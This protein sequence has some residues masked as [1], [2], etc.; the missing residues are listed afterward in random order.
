MITRLGIDI[1]GTFTDLYSFDSENGSATTCK[2]PTTKED[3]TVGVLKAIAKSQIQLRSITD[4]IHGS[5]IATNAVIERKLPTVP[6][7]TTKGFRDIIEIGRYH[8]QDLYDPYQTKPLPLTSRRYRY[9]VN[10]RVDSSGN[11]LKDLDLNELSQV[12]DKIR[13]LRTDTIAI[14]FVNS[15]ANPVNEERARELILSELPGSFVSTSS[16]VLKKI[17]PLGRFV[18]TILNAALKPIITS[19]LNILLDKLHQGGFRGN[20]WLAQSSGGIIASELLKDNPELM[21][22]SGPSLGV[23]ASSHLCK[24]IDKNHVIT[25]DMGG[26]S[27][28]ICLVDYGVALV[29][30]ERQ[31]DWDMPV[32]APMMDIETIGAG[33][34]SIA[35][36]DPGGILKVGPISAGG[37]PGP[38]CYG[39]GGTEVT[40]TDANLVLG[41]LNALQKLGT[42]VGL[43]KELALSAI[44][45]LGERIEL[46]WLDCARGIIRIVVENMA[47]AV[48]R[49]SISK[50]KDP[51]D[52]ALVAFGGAGP[53]H[54]CEV[55]RLLGIPYVI[56]GF[57]SGVLCAFG[58][59]IADVIHNIETTFYAPLDAVE[60]D[61]LNQEY[62]SLEQKAK[63]ILN[64]EGFSEQN[65]K[66][67]RMAE[68][69]YV[70]QTYEIDTE[71]PL[72]DL[73]RKDLPEIKRLFDGMHEDRF[74]V[75]FAEDTAAFVNLRCNAIGETKKED[76]PHFSSITEESP[77]AE[78]PTIFDEREMYFNDF[79][80]P[81]KA[82]VFSYK[83]LSPG[84]AF[85]GPFSIELRESTVI[86]PPNCSA[87]IDRFKNILVKV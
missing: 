48:K 83:S 3:Y 35:W 58:A 7:I 75:C 76:L 13:K 38:I 44:Q 86:G 63:E 2:V 53:M 52:Y 16:S 6:F 21:L 50:N 59:T 43:N 67:K 41:R 14:G 26:T 72:R 84:M 17:R 1:G 22:L 78:N 71:I 45:K 23:V 66:L 42:E 85:S 56:C 10:E 51:R 18:I 74:G 65:I 11:V 15:Y 19:Y 40:V 30:T 60:L 34:G 82:K 69:R 54:A 8:R 70:G 37:D 81:V 77:S 24:A 20:L 46:S 33:G 5:T 64:K 25:M 79:E 62:K 31:I 87:T 61:E 39:R 47:N 27:T 28:D 68:M 9:E 36:I 49:V 29:T 55:A 32:P 73:T 12:I 57:Y 80:Q 4:I